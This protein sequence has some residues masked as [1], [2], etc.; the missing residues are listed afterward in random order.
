[1]RLLGLGQLPLRWYSP[2]I[3]TGLHRQQQHNKLTAEAAAANVSDWVTQIP[4]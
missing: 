4:L 2:L 3:Q 1:M